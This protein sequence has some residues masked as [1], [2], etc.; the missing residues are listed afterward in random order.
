MKKVLAVLMVGLFAAGA[1]AQNPSGT[2]SAQ[3]NE[4]NTKSQKS[5][6]ARKAKRP[7]KAAP[8]QLNPAATGVAGTAIPA[9]K[10]VDAGEAR[11]QTRDQ[12]RPGHAKTT[13][14]GTPN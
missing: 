1:Y 6:E 4:F 7:H 12:R 11:A 8:S 14:G 9:G 3:G 10:S 2:S 5:A 13:Q